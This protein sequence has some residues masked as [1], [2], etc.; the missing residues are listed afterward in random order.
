MCSFPVPSRCPSEGHETH[1][2]SPGC[3]EAGPERHAARTVCLCRPPVPE[4]EAKRELISEGGRLSSLSAGCSWG[5]VGGG[6]SQCCRQLELPKINTSVSLQSSSEAHDITAG[7]ETCRFQ[8]K[9]G[10]KSSQRLHRQRQTRGQS[11]S[12]QQNNRRR[13]GTEPRS[14]LLGKVLPTR[15]LVLSY[16]LYYICFYTH[17]GYVYYYYYYG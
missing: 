15:S 14:D 7:S 2:P 16:Q 4:K 6:T 5:G 8:H 1:L 3:E 11:G 12:A 10:G 17:T 13:G 9:G